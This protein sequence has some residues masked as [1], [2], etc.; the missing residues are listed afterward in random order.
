MTSEQWQQIKSTFEAALSQP[1]EKRNQYVHSLCQG[2][3]ELEAEVTALLVAHDSAGAFLQAPAAAVIGY[4]PAD[5]FPRTLKAGEVIAGRFEIL[6]FLNSGGMGEVYEALDRELREHIALKTIRPEIASSP[7]V[8]ER[9]K[10]EVKQARGISHP[11]VCRV[12]D[13]FNHVTTSG[14]TIWFLTMELLRGQ[15]LAEWLR[16]QGPIKPKEALELVRQMVAGLAAA[17]RLEI[18]HR[19]FKTGNVML[20]DDGPG[21][22]R[23]VVTDFGLA[24]NIREAGGVPAT[25]GSG[26]PDYMAPEQLRGEQVGFAADQF[27]LGV[28]MCEMLTGHR[29]K[30]AGDYRVLPRDQRLSHRWVAVLRRCLQDRPQDRFANIADV[31]S[32]LDTQKRVKARWWISAAAVSLLTAGFLASMAIEKS[33]DLIQGPKQITGDTDLSTDPSLSRDGK[34]LAY[35]SDRAGGGRSDVWVQHLLGTDPPVRVGTEATPDKPINI[36]PD[37]SLVAFRSDREGGGIYLANTMTQEL[38]W[39]DPKM[40]IQG[41]RLLVS[42]GRDPKFSPDG[43]SVLYWTGD[44]DESV[45]SGQL[46]VIPVTGGS[47]VRL[48]ANFK[49]ARYGIWSPDGKY[50]LFTGC[51]DLT[52]RL[53]NCWEW[54]A[55]SLDGSRVADTGALKLLRNQKIALQD[56]AVGAWHGETGTVLFSGI[57]DDK[58]SLWEL[59]LSFRDLHA[60]GPAKQLTLGN[61]RDVTP[62][63]AA[64]GT[65]AYGHLV[66]AL[67]IW[68]IE[69]ASPPS[70]APIRITD[71]AGIDG[72]PYISHNGHWLAYS[73][74]SRDS[75]HIEIR[76]LQSGSVSLVQQ[77]NPD[78]ISP[79]IDD[80]GKTLVFEGRGGQ[81]AGIFAV[82][83]GS[84][85]RKLCSRCNN[86]TGWFDGARAVFYREGIP[87]SIKMADLN[88][89][90]ST[91]VLEANGMSLGN[92]NWSAENQYLLFTA[93]A[94]SGKNQIF[95]A[96][97]SSSTSK[98]AGKWIPITD[99]MEWSDR[100][101]WSGDGKTV[102]YISNRDHFHC[103]WGQ[104]FNPELGKPEG[105]PFH[106]KGYHDL[107]ISPV[108]VVWQTFGFS[109]A[110]DS[111]YLNPGEENQTIWVG[112]LKRPTRLDFLNPFR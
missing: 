76:N 35:I 4:F 92:A 87:S 98:I 14:Q 40:V 20:V 26:T 110:G 63:L 108:L 5:G 38:A 64:N 68:R 59:D 7:A 102:F 19:D 69:H 62:S 6:R 23:A 95:A 97:F 48:A 88:T 84:P 28:I 107:R 11:N 46:Y 47:P 43:K 103:V 10:R 13:L 111:I 16:G 1:A 24:L 71:D 66:G 104:R 89:G 73:R 67:H 100:P 8:L 33:G 36:S 42:G 12:Y 22:L 60:A 90:K 83:L 81:D 53:A 61:T 72:F 79:V 93:S 109:V 39:N 51:I 44:R 41:E 27:A 2:N 31:I 34:M 55:T 77:S 25:A 3:S 52:H 74:G 65:L 54:W 45:A 85:P 21:K 82:V 49:D 91:A 105:A 17:H 18:V 96:H 94:A 15:S 58:T 78:E 99:E 86:P 56:D 106:I 101:R 32:I 37:G 75:R 29:P 9:F 80:S 70:S 57:S 112:N 50:V 30:R